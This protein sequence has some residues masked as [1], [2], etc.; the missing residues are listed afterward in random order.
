MN[1]INYQRKLDEVIRQVVQ[2]EKVP[3]LLLHSCCAPCSSYTLEYLSEFFNITVLYYNPNIAPKGEYEYRVAEQERLI[4]EM[5]SK[6]PIRLIRGDYL[7][8]IFLDAVKGFEKEPEGG[9]R[10]RICYRLRMEEAARIAS[11][12]NFDFFTTTLTISPL[13]DSAVINTIGDELSQTYK[14]KHLPSDFKKKGGY[15]RSIE[16]SKEHHLYRQNFCGCVFSHQKDE[17]FN[18]KNGRLRVR[19][20]KLVNKNGTPIQLRGMST[21]G[22]AWNPDTY[23][24]DSLKTLVTDWHISV[25]RIAVYTHEWGGYCTDEWK[26]KDE[27]HKTIDEL[28]AICKKLGIYCII[29]WHI[30]NEGS[31]N[32]NITIEDARRFWTYMA[33][34]HKND[35]HILYE[36]CN[37]PNGKD[38]GW[39]EVKK[40]T[41]DIIPLIRSIDPET[42]II[43]GTPTWSQD[44]DEAA[45]NPP[46]NV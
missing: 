20:G 42:V 19:D 9:K 17:P 40:Y 12:M 31:G 26:S 14:V 25:F 3:S 24:E 44:V 33:A 38:V 37:E 30:L 43:C 29:D 1:K 5:K 15:Q 34:K 28:I 16:L 13:K 45:E 2:S 21:H 23:N 41:D 18:I 10:C 22:L 6:N 8:E 7:P 32:P 35:T 11:E 4:N 46:K 39:S 36:I 27:Y